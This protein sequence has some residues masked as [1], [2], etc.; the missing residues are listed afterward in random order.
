MG[1]DFI[2]KKNRQFKRC[3]DAAYE[4]H[5]ADDLFSDVPADTSSVIVGFL[6]PGAALEVGNQVMQL[7]AGG[8]A[9]GL[10]FYHG[11]VP[12]VELD[13]E[14]AVLAA[15]AADE[16]GEPLT[17]EVVDVEDGLVTLRLHK[18]YKH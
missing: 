12:V 10:R 14:S 13:G 7:P 15:Q 3:M 9:S 17:A 6:L 5:K 18:P 1:E 2:E 8:G 16:A 4:D 11:I